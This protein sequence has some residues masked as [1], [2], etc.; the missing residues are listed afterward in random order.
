MPPGD[1][2]EV[3][4]WQLE[5]RSIPPMEEKEQRLARVRRASNGQTDGGFL[6]G[7]ADLTIPARSSLSILVDQSHTTDAYPILETSGGAGS[8]VR[9]TYAEA[10]VDPKGE[11]GNRND[12]D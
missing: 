7:R 11:K 6:R 9:L 5:P 2:G 4:G 10:L 3:S 1:Y 12:I 8:A